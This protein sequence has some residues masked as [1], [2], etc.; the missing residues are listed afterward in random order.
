[1]ERRLEIED[2]IVTTRARDHGEVAPP[3][4]HKGTRAVAKPAA[5]PVYTACLPSGSALLLNGRSG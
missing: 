4:V 2:T 3:S 5:G 1:V